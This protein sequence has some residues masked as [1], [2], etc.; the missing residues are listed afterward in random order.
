[1]VGDV[2]DDTAAGPRA[3]E[4]ADQLAAVGR[5]AG[6]AVGGQNRPVA[7]TENATGRL[8]SVTRRVGS[9]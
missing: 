3:V 9:T 4:D 6:Q 8:T 1:V 5:V 2:D 7:L